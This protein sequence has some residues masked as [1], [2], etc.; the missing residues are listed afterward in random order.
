MFAARRFA[1]VSKPMASTKTVKVSPAFVQ[2]AFISNGPIR[3]KPSPTSPKS[4]ESVIDTKEISSLISCIK[5]SVT[6][7]LNPTLE[8]F[9]LKD[10]VAVITG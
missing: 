1:T 5:E 8:K 3:N 2:R 10:K 6:P 4:S 7:K 9:T